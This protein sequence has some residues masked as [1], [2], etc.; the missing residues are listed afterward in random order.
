ML[1]LV[2]QLINV[3]L[4]TDR[5]PSIGPAMPVSAASASTAQSVRKYKAQD[6]WGGPKQQ[7]QLTGGRIIVFVA[8]GISYAEMREAYEVMAK[9]IVALS[10]NRNYITY[11]QA[12]CT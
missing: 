11:S 6:R 3:Q 8:G 2:E 1:G 4:P 7:T 12:L 10:C 5:F 9:V